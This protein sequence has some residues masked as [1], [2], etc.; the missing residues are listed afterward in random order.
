M[1]ITVSG[2]VALAKCLSQRGI[3]GKSG[4]FGRIRTDC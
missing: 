3:E 1:N 2:T 4:T